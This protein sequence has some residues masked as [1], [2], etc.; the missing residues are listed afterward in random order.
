MLFLRSESLGF[1]P[2]AAQSLA[3]TAAA[4]HQLSTVGTGCRG[5]PGVL[6]E[7]GSQVEVGTRSAQRLGGTRS[8]RA[9][10]GGRAG[11][12]VGD[13]EGR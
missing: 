10:A 5:P 11:T 6:P 9:A 4:Q 2:P 13:V 8:A 3:V 12:G 7:Q 1:T